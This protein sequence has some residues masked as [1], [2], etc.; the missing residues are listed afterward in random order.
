MGI[1]WKVRISLQ[2]RCKSFG[3]GMNTKWLNDCYLVMNWWTTAGTQ[4]L[5][6]GPTSWKSWILS[7]RCW[8]Q[9]L[10]KYVIWVMI[11]FWILMRQ[12]FSTIW[13][14]TTPTRK[15][16]NKYSIITIIFGCLQWILPLLMNWTAITLI[17]RLTEIIITETIIRRM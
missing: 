1:E 14:W 7:E 9:M 5:Y 11:D 4:S 17:W 2:K 6:I 15:W 16:M 12:L 13:I 10:D 3:I 8:S